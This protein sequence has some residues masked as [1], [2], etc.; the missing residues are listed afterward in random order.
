MRITTGMMQRNTL[1]DINR[2]NERVQRAQSRASSNKQI[3]RPSDDPFNAARALQLR[4]SLAGVK[5]YQRSI[6][7]AQGWQEAAELGMSTVTEAVARARDLLVQGSSTTADPTSRGSIAAE[8]DELIKTVKQAGN[9]S[10]QGRY[11]FAGTRT[12]QPPYVDGPVDAYQG[13]GAVVARQVGPGVSLEIGVTGESFLGSG[14]GDGKLLDTLRGIADHLRGGDTASMQGTDLQRIDANLDELLGVRA[15]NGAR[16]NRLD[17][18]LSRMGEIEAATTLQLSETEDADI[19]ATLIE[20][21]SQQNA[22]QAAL[23]VGANVIQA[24]LM[25]FLR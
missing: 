16:Q 12:D 13:S 22:Y 6:E 1:A 23:K 21:T 4:G 5:E 24:S 25:D 20:L 8:I 2:L 11:V 17:A 14:G 7:D 10:F 15:L 9:T 19:A 3:E 18:A